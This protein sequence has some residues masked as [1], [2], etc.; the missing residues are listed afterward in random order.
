MINESFDRPELPED[1][2][3]VILDGAE[4]QRLRELKDTNWQSKEQEYIGRLEGLRIRLGRLDNPRFR[5]FQPFIP[6]R[7]GY[8]GSR[9]R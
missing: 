2:D 4:Y 7:H 3:M 8:H 6:T 1:F 9:Q 5:Q